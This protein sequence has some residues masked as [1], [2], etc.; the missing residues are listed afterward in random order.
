M[1]REMAEWRTG[2]LAERPRCRISLWHV[3]YLLRVDV[4]LMASIHRTAHSGT[5]QAPRAK[6][7]AQTAEA[8]HRH[9]PLGV[10]PS[11]RPP[12][13]LGGTSSQ[14]D[15]GCS[16]ACVRRRVRACVPR[17]ICNSWQHVQ[18]KNILKWFLLIHLHRFGLHF[19]SRFS[20]FASR[21]SLLP[22]IR[23][24]NK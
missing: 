3:L 2:G 6:W 24:A 8:T 18:H 16:I 17:C 20:V 9:S 7:L 21:F 23:P 19:S 11:V 1:G 13:R 12:A 14:P 15:D 4:L 10:R 22:A 5:K